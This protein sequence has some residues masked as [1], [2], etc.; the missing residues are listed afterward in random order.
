M[1]FYTHAL[2]AQI[3]CVNTEAGREKKRRVVNTNPREKKEN[4]DDDRKKERERETRRD[5][6]VRTCS[7]LVALKELFLSRKC[8]KMFPKMEETFV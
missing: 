7:M 4:A 6:V 1:L 3:V 8:S 2:K 5:I